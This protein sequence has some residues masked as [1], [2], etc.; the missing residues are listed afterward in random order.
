MDPRYPTRFANPFRSA[1]CADLVPRVDDP[2]RLDI[3]KRTR[4]V[5]VSLLRATGPDPD[6]S[7]V[8][9]LAD[10]SQLP[11]EYR[12]PNRNPYFAY[13][14]LSR[15]SNLVTTRSN[16]YAVWITVG[17]FEVSPANPVPPLPPAQY[18]ALYPDGYWLGREL[19]SDTGEIRRHRA[20]YLIDRSIPVGFVR[21]QDLNS[22]STIL[23]KRFIE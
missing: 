10:P 6:A 12:D 23:L 11:G 16:V 14:R 8:P 4:P 15:V 2:P 5:N 13:Q 9:L 22:A 1:A 19:G 20:F 17:Y 7:S 3:L 21:G 18:R